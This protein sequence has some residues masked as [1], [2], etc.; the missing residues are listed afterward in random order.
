MS[1]CIRHTLRGGV[2]CFMPRL[3]PIQCVSRNSHAEV[4][5]C[6]AADEGTLTSPT[7]CL[8][9]MDAAS[10]AAQNTQRV[11]DRLHAPS[12]GAS[13]SV[14]PSRAAN[15]S[16]RF[17]PPVL[18]YG[19]MPHPLHPSS[20]EVFCVLT[21]WVA[22]APLERLIVDAARLAQDDR[23]PRLSVVLK[24]LAALA[25]A[26]NAWGSL[27][28]GTCLVH[29]DLKP[30]NVIVS[31]EPDV[32]ATLID[33]DTA[34]FLDEVAAVV[35]GPHDAALHI[36]GGSYGYAAPEILMC[37]LGAANE[38]VDV[39]AFGVVAHEALCGHNPY[40]F[41]SQYACQQQGAD[42]AEF[43]RSFFRK[44]GQPTVDAWLP[45]DIANA[46][47]ASLAIDPAQRLHPRELV[48]AMRRLAN[49]YEGENTRCTYSETVSCWEQTPARCVVA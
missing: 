14:E 9:V 6:R 39:Y 45:C 11:L 31:L 3:K 17:F 35:Q 28:P 25:D 37:G 21:P 22:G 19:V 27:Q 43:W 12:R 38:C 26:V 8:K 15:L 20:G 34:F 2:R 7:Y 24:A 44:G 10:P 36:P 32:Q 13:N 16:A 46:L 40:P 33:Y 4:F 42:A 29:Q 1:G 18:H 49:K 48:H 47:Y 30:S 41:S 5:L 23:G